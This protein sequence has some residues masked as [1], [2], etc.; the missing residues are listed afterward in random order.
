[1][2]SGTP[3]A[4][5]DNS[6]NQLSKTVNIYKFAFKYSFTADQVSLK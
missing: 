3:H 6:L 1:M 4:N 2:V 5:V